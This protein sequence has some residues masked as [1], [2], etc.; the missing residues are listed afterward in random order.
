MSTLDL[1]NSIIFVPVSPVKPAGNAGLEDLEEGTGEKAG[2]AGVLEWMGVI[3][4]LTMVFVGGC[5][6]IKL[7]TSSRPY[8]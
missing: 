5:C 8:R 2:G 6:V 4:G 7:F 3:A 1:N